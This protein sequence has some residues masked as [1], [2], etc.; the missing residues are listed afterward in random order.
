[1]C[2]RSLRRRPMASAMICARG[3]GPTLDSPARPRRRPPRQGI[4]S[5]GPADD[6]VHLRPAEIAND[7]T[8]DALGSTILSARADMIVTDG[9]Q[10]WETCAECHGLNG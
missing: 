7:R 5:P 3:M 10:P 4:S 8:A 2:C 9:M 1:M 6:G